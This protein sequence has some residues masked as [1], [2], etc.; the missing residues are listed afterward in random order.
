MSNSCEVNNKP[1]SVKEFFK[2]KMFWKTFIG[3]TIGA[4]G[5]GLYYY[6]VGCKSGSCGITSSPIG[7]IIMGSAIGFFATNSS[8]GCKL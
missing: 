8:C 3:M 7:G 1:K 5:G 2:S 6:Y 4:I